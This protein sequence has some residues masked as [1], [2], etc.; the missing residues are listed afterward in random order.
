MADRIKDS[1]ITKK[2]K[3]NNCAMHPGCEMMFFFEIKLI[4]IFG[5]IVEE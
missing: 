5:E 3:K 4:S 2:Q 1:E